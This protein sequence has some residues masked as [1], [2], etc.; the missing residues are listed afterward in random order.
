MVTQQEALTMSFL[1]SLALS[2]N[3]SS[4]LSSNLPL[5]TNTLIGIN[6]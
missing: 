4:T 5:Q 6:V 1:V 3:S 2:I